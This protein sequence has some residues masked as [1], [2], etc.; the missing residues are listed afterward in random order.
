[1]VNICKL[2]SFFFFFLE[3]LP[4]VTFNSG[5]PLTSLGRGFLSVLT[6]NV[7]SVFHKCN[8]FHNCCLYVWVPVSWEAFYS[9]ITAGDRDS[10]KLLCSFWIWK[11]NY[12]SF[13][14]GEWKAGWKRG[15]ITVSERITLLRTSRWST[16]AWT[17]VEVL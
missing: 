9:P 6:R 16:A 3:L 10:S 7:I 2:M 14:N 5:Y 4:K 17:H 8:F 12:S 1:M 13:Q 11:R 15:Y